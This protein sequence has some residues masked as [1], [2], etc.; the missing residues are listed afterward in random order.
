MATLDH[1]AIT[2]YS[3][4]PDSVSTT[5]RRVEMATLRG[6]VAQWG[7]ADPRLAEDISI[8]AH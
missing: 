4:I 8:L 3:N 6:F 2:Y 5:R 1:M 7:I